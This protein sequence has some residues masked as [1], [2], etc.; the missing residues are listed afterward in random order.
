MA[1]VNA[2]LISFSASGQIAKAVVYFSWKGINAVRQYVIPANP[3]SDDQ[4][5]QRNR[6]TDAVAA[7]HAA[8]YDADDV[9]AIEV[10]VIEGVLDQAGDVFT[11]SGAMCK[12]FIIEDILGNT[13]ERIRN[14]SSANAQPTEFEVHVQKIGGGNAPMCYYGTRKTHFP[15][16]KVLVDEGGATWGENIT[17]LIKNTLYYFYFDVGTS[18]TDFARTGIY[19]QRTPAA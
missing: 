15:N 12:T 10:E 1:K 17:G 4:I 9:T 3:K 2:P 5:T 16:S 11:P 7:W 8:P 6:M 13:W 14:G 19:Q 18:G